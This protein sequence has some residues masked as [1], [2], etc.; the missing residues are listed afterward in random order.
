MANHLVIPDAHAHPDYHNNRFNWLGKLVADVKPDVVVCLGD[1]ADMPS[2]CSYDKGTKG[3]EGRRYVK[4]LAAAH[5]AQERFFHEIKKHKKKLP[6]FVMLEGNHEHRIERAISADAAHLDGII[7]NDDLGYEDYGWEY[8]RYDGATPGVVD[9]DGVAYAHFFTSGIMNRP[10]GG[11][12]PAAAVIQKQFQSCTQGHAH[13][14]DFAIRTR[15]DGRHIMGCLAGVYQD[16]DAD[17][18]GVANRLWWRGVVHKRDVSRGVY[19]PNFI[20]MHT[21]KKEYR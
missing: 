15:A 19:D 20:S 1:W 6:R 14:A 12:H 21:I 4:D 11:V 8:V 17:F 2:L 3:Y 18:A 9:I 16:Y 10:I 13:V 7:S 5:D